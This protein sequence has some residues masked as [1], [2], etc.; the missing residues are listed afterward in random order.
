MERDWND[1]T[2]IANRDALPLP[3]V[4][5]YDQLIARVQDLAYHP[6]LPAAEQEELTGLLTYDR[7]ETVA[8]TAVLDYLRAAERHVTAF[9]PLQSEAKR[10]D[11]H[12]GEIPRCAEW[13]K[14]A[15]RLVKA[16]R[17]ILADDDYAAYLD[18]V[19]AGKPRAR[20]TVDQLLDRI[21]DARDESA[22]S[23]EFELRHQPAS[24]QEK[25]IAYILEDLEK[26]QQLREQLKER[27]HKIGR[28]QRKSRGLS[29]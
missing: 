20:L 4:H 21:E 16:G 13:R 29:M 8:R 11:V 6:E 9:E 3:L 12:I 5:G 19:A 14:E 24:K 26:L 7:T 22:K 10:L 17:A 25:G 2:A 15:L 23:E 27:Q 28:Q 18:A 1:L